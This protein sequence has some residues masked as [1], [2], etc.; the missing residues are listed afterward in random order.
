MTQELLLQQLDFNEKTPVSKIVNSTESVFRFL[1]YS[2][3]GSEPRKKDKI[4]FY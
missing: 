1:Q 2:E 4:Y 3:C